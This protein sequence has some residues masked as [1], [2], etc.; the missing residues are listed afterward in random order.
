M[1]APVEPNKLP[2]FGKPLNA[3][4]HL[5]YSIKK[6]EKFP[7]ALIDEGYEAEVLPMRDYVIMELVNTITDKSD[8]QRKVLDEAIVAKWRAEILDSNPPEGTSRSTPSTVLAAK[9]T[10]IDAAD[11]TSN[12]SGAELSGSQWSARHST[13]DVSPRM[14][15]WV[16]AEVKYKAEVFT[17][18]NCIEALD[19]VWKSDTCV[20]EGLRKALEE[21]VRP[22]E[23][24]PEAEKDWHPGSNGQVLDLVHPSIYPLVYGQSR[25]LESETC[26]VDD[27]TSWIGKGSV[28]QLPAGSAELGGEW[29]ED[30]QWLPAEFEVAPSTEDVTVKSYINNLHPRYH[31]DLYSII[32]QIVSKAIPLWDRVLSRVIAPPMQPRVSDWSNSFQGYSERDEIFQ[33]PDQEEDEDDDEYDARLDAGDYKDMRDVIQPEPG[34]FKTPAERI[35]DHRDRY[36]PNPPQAPNTEPCVDLRKDHGRLQ[37]IVKLANIHLTPENP[38]YPGGSWHVEGQANESICASA[39]YYYSSLNITDSYLS[40]RQQTHDGRFKLDYAQDE[41]KAVEYIYGFNNGEPTIQNLGKVLTRE[42]RLLCFP[43]VMQH[44]VSPF[45][46]AD[47]S[48]PG[49]RKLLALFLV[50]PHLKIIST[51]N[52]PPQQHA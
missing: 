40:F 15:D 14:F 43:N 41:W 49:Y 10:R 5:K 19:G 44:R 33:F 24:I 26:N 38:G 42:R 50:D 12:M 48:K 1:A 36:E 52:V 13:M 37:I 7:I 51:E 47:P 46:L 17:Q 22:L 2:G 34:N 27:C 31:S 39:L 18:L 28:L 4:D 16:I 29:S 9:L 3:R 32:S 8:W 21:A 11:G 45:Q 6:T 25:I 35:R 30:Y 20:S 23:D